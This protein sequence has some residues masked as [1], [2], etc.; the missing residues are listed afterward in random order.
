[1]SEEIDTQDTKTKNTTNLVRLTWACPEQGIRRTAWFTT[2]NK[3]SQFAR[4]EK[5]SDEAHFE[6]VE[7]PKKKLELCEWLNQN[8]G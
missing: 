3:A 1:M 8:F 6:L 2:N 5:I 4:K 7:I